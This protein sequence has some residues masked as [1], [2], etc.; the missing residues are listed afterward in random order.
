[1]FVCLDVDYRVRGAVAAAVLFPSWEAPA[2]CG[3]QIAII[4]EV[5]PYTPGSF[6]L[7]ELPCLLAV[8]GKIPG[9]LGALR[10]VVI[11]GY[12]WLNGAGHKGLGA[13]L[14]HQLEGCIPVVGVAKNS[15][16]GA[17]AFPVL[18]GASKRPLWVTAAGLSLEDAAAGVMAMHGPHRIPTMLQRVDQ[19]CRRSLPHPRWLPSA[20]SCHHVLYGTRFGFS[21]GATFCLGICTMSR[22]NSSLPMSPCTS[23]Y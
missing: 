20:P 3:E 23:M 12:V 21:S 10:L 8:L 4:D 19:L 1:M 17:A 5:A 14:F 7:R 6:F 9:G 13:H 18:R 15:F 22:E 16:T 2:P 11:D